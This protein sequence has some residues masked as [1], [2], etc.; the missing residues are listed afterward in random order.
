MAIGESGC[1]QMQSSECGGGRTGGAGIGVETVARANPTREAGYEE[2]VVVVCRGGW[3]GG[4][5]KISKPPLPSWLPSPLVSL[6]RRAGGAEEKEG[7]RRDESAW[8]ALLWWGQRLARLS[9][10]F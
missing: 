3:R 7:L 8:R 9:F 1:R 5:A 6:P 4:S 2:K 10:A